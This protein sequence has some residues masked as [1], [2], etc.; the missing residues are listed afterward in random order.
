MLDKFH[1]QLLK[2]VKDIEALE[3]RLGKV[4]KRSAS[5]TLPADFDADDLIARVEKLEKAKAPTRASS[6]RG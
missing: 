6:A 3:K 5:P 2:L 1:V 4:E